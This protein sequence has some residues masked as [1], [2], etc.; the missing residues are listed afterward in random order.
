MVTAVYAVKYAKRDFHFL[1]PCGI[2]HFS[3]KM[4]PPI[5]VRHK[6]D[7]YAPVP[8]FSPIL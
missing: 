1:L 2:K 7:I 6:A 4:Y 8:N 3:S 5:L